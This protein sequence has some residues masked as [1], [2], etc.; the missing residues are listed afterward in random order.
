MPFQ[1]VDQATPRRGA[2]ALYLAT[3]GDELA[4]AYGNDTKLLERRL[5]AGPT[6][7]RATRQK[8]VQTITSMGF[9]AMLVVPALDH[10]FMWSR[11]P[12]PA[13]VVGDALVAF[14]FFIVLLV[15]N[16]N[17]FASGTVEIAPEQKVVSTG[18]YA[19]VRHPMYLRGLFWLIGMALALGS[20]WGMLIFL[21]ILPALTW[22][23]LDEERLLSKELPGYMEYRQKVRYRLVPFIW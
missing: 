2:V 12:P 6:A 11:V 23:I 1:G 5:Y 20:W 17:T 21:L 4:A 3:P 13:S 15:F 16:E 19:L 7:E 10:R 22:R 9:I 14:G 8:I 18:V